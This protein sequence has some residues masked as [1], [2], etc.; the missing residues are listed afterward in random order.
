MKKILIIIFGLCCITPWS[1][2]EIKYIVKKQIF[3]MIRKKVAG[4]VFQK[5]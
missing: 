4:E 1:I 3:L 5:K 2:A